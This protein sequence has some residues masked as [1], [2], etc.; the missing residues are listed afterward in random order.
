CSVLKS[1]TCRVLV[2]VF[3]NF[4]AIN[5]NPN[6][7]FFP[8]GI[9][10][11]DAALQTGDEVSQPLKLKRPLQFYDTQFNVVYVGT[12][13]LLSSQPPPKE[14]QYLSSGFPLSFP[15]VAP[16][17]VDVDTSVGRG[18][19]YYRSDSSF[20]SL[21]RATQ[22]IQQ[23]FPGSQFRPTH[24]VIST[25][26][27]VA[28]FKEDASKG[29]WVSS[30]QVVL[31]GNKTDTFALFLYADNG[32][33]LSE[34]SRDVMGSE[35]EL[36]VLAGFSR[37][38]TSVTDELYHN[39]YSSMESASKLF[40]EGNSGIKGLWIFHIGSSRYSFQKIIG[41]AGPLAESTEKP[42]TTT[43]IQDHNI[44]EEHNTVTPALIRDEA[45]TTPVPPVN[46]SASPSLCGSILLDCSQDGYCTDFPRGP[47]CLCRSGYYGNGRQCLPMGVS[48]RLNGKLSGH[49]SVG[50]ADVQVDKADVH[51]YAVPG[52]GRVYVSI[53][54]IPP[55]V[56][57]A[58]MAVS[59]LVSTF[60][61]LFA[62]TVQNHQNGFSITGAEFSHRAEMTFYPGNLRLNITQHAR[63]M[64]YLNHLKMEVHVSGNLPSIP[65]GA[66]VQFQ[67]F[68]ETLHYNQSV[69]TSSSLH[70]YMVVSENGGSET[71]SYLLHQNISIQG[72]ENAP[73][74]IP[75]FHQLSV[76][77]V[78]VMYS[79]EGSILKYSI[80]N[81]VGPVGGELPDLVELNP[82]QS[83]KHYCDPMALCLPG[84]G[85]QYHCQCAMG[86]RGDGRNCYDVDECTEGLSS[87][88]PHSECVNMPGSHHCLCEA[89]Y[90][91]DFDWK[92]CVGDYPS[93]DPCVGWLMFDVLCC[94]MTDIDECVLKLC[95]PLASCSNTLGSFHCRC[96]PGYEGDGFLCQ[97]QSIDYL[98]K[99]LQ[100]WGGD[101]MLQDYIP[102]CDEKGQY[103][104]LQCLGSTGH[105]W[106]V[107]SRGQERV[108]TRTLPGTAHANSPLVPRAETLCERWRTTL[109]SH[110]GG[111]PD[112]QDYMPQC[113]ARGHF[114]SVQCYGNSSYCWCVDSQGREVM[115]TRS[116][117]AVKPACIS[118][119]PLVVQSSVYPVVTSSPSGPA[120]LFAHGSEIQVI[121]LDDSH[122]VQGKSAVL[123]SEHDSV[124]VGI[125]F[126][127]QE[128]TLYWSD[129]AR[130]SISKVSL[131]FGA[132]PVTIIHTDVVTPEGV[133][134]DAVHRLLFWVDSGS[135]Q[136]EVADLNGQNRKVLFDTGLVNPRAITVDF[137]SSTLFWTD[138]DRDDPRI[139]SSS[140]DGLRRKVLVGKGLKLPN[141]LT[142]DP[143]THQLCWADAGTKKL[144]CVAADG[145]KRQEI[146]S[147]LN[148][149]FSL[150]VYN[151]HIYYTDWERDGIMVI[152]KVTG[153]HTEYLPV[154][155]DNLYGITLIPSQCL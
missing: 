151:E 104:P 58:L 57:W 83:G 65:S 59:P 119:V 87:C 33:Q 47:C 146:N 34:N 120:L 96:W 154:A 98:L 105:C 4:Y 79:S 53:S 147:E 39:L 155:K 48:Q 123:L 97:P 38:D 143:V 135:D 94:V 64:D 72:C 101:A 141:A 102:Q 93:P 132:E 36:G 62:L 41:A 85:L 76:E 23:A 17:L 55:Q 78:M 111:Q 35:A 60:G 45:E 37:G 82:C 130:R 13:G 52:E 75:D 44:P 110:Y 10:E 122:P 131:V 108:G 49:V 68:K 29:Y 31:A 112:P 118:S 121:P 21:T 138:W 54:P 46:G 150:T 95:H 26:D 73:L 125:S 12:N 6:D 5:A 19:V 109:L 124:V 99:G 86:F 11:G 20:S 117:D 134:V 152:N 92:V 74:T 3:L 42:I 77:H 70:Q 2:L 63:G 16:F 129:M 66:K 137:T 56:G 8:F 67:P 145:T 14:D 69:I 18:S 100:S 24:L 1:K 114:L 126:D 81:T 71:F 80:I 89:G 153:N 113:D 142:L 107:D 32:T 91:F 106:C 148:Y 28:C 25:W 9:S 103:K 88:G 116:H 115:G 90:E 144:E 140:L 136:I 30:F 149:P 7:K 27:H 128:N 43:P 127:C 139:E 15:A 22:A 40:Q 61:W 84:E 133:A 51:G 50:A